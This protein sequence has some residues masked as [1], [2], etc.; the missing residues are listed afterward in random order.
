MP[1]RIIRRIIGDTYSHASLALDKDLNELYSFARRN[2]RFPMIA[3]FIH[4]NINTGIFA[5]NEDAQCILYELEI[6]DEIYES[7][8]SQIKDMINHYDTYKYNFIGLVLNN[9]GIPIERRYH[10]VCSQ[11]VAYMLGTNGALKFPKEINLIRPADFCELPEL[12]EVYKG[13]LRYVR[14]HADL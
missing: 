3:G 8:K 10:F 12:N 11:F 5:Q 4:E 2:L 1:A 13:K 14:S 6:D 9:F 7:I